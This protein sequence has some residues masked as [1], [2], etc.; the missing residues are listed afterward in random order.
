MPRYRF[1]WTN[2]PDEF[3]AELAGALGL[4]GDPSEA[5]RSKYGAR[6]KERF[7]QDAWAFLRDG[8]LAG[9]DVARSSVVDMLISYGLG[10]T[11]A[12]VDSAEGE[13]AYLRSCRNAPSLRQVVLGHFLELGEGVAEQAGIMEQAAKAAQTVKKIVT[14]ERE[15]EPAAPPPGPG[16]DGSPTLEQWVEGLLAEWLGVPEIK[17]DQDG[18]M[19]IPAG[20]AVVFV[21]VHDE[22]FPTVEVFSPLLRDFK[23]EPAVYEAVNA[24]NVKLRIARVMVIEQGPTIILQADIPAGSLAPLE[25]I[26][27]VQLVGRAADHFDTLLQARFGGETMFEE[28]E[29]ESVDV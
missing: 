17:R 8:W 10:D 25:L 2:L 11:N 5:L 23:P 27:T 19:W 3:L 26:S 18:D 14:R 7:V 13:L 20:S 1:A 6:P 21:R 15:P 29:E 4:K 28:D 9:D 22:E 24:I 12:D 16:G